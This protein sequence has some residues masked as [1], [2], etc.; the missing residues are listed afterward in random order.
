MERVLEQTPQAIR[1][2]VEQQHSPNGRVHDFAFRRELSAGISVATLR[3]NG[4][5]GVLTREY[6]GDLPLAVVDAYPDIERKPLLQLGQA[7]YSDPLWVEWSERESKIEGPIRKKVYAKYGKGILVGPGGEP[8]DN[9]RAAQNRRKARKPYLTADKYNHRIDLEKLQDQ[10]AAD[11]ALVAQTFIHEG[12]T[13]VKL[14]GGY[15]P[16]F[17]LSALGKVGPEGR[18]YYVSPT[19]HLRERVFNSVFDLLIDFRQVKGELGRNNRPPSEGLGHILPGRYLRNMKRMFVEPYARDFDFYE[20]GFRDPAVLR[21]LTDAFYAK[22]PLTPIS[23]DLPPFPREVRSGSA[24][25]VIE[26]DRLA[27]LGE[28]KI[29]ELLWE[30]DRI[31]KPGGNFVIREG[32][33]AQAEIEYYGQGLLDKDYKKWTAPKGVTHSGRWVVYHKPHNRPVSIQMPEIVQSV[34]QDLLETSEVPEIKIH[35]NGVAN[36]VVEA[37]EKA[38]PTPREVLVTEVSVAQQAGVPLSLRWFK[39]KGLLP[40]LITEFGG[41]LDKATAFVA[42]QTAKSVSEEPAV[43][44]PARVSTLMIKVPKDAKSSYGLADLSQELGLPKGMLRKA[45]RQMGVQ[46]FKARSR[47]Q[48]KKDGTGLSMSYTEYVVIRDALKSQNLR[49]PRDKSKNEES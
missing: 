31:L 36:G 38:P 25:T 8:L 10:E 27:T 47:S 43:E 34:T 14:L 42:S 1:Q 23:H 30:A 20:S 40:T 29:E 15:E 21:G 49:P 24:D 48:G 33:R 3:R 17:L 26:M 35:T 44:E 41:N 16:A 39:E 32:S 13:V 7:D 22:Y 5:L 37:K 11:E 6:A 12:S 9:G 45:V 19:T 28:D 2:L 4:L 46:T 18:V